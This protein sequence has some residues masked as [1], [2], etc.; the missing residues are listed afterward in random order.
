[1]FAGDLHKRS[2][3]IT[4]IEGYV[5]CCRKTQEDIMKACTQLGV[6]KFVSLGDWYD[7]GYNADVAASLSDYDIDIKM[8]NQLNGEF[9]GVIGNHIR[10]GMDSN[11]ELHIIQP[12]NVYKSRAEVTRTEQIMRTPKVL[13]VH[14]VQISFMHHMMGVDN[15]EAYK[16]MREPWAKYHIAL[17]HTPAVIPN[18][19]L[20]KA[21]YGYNTSSNTVIGRTLEGVDLAIVGDIHMPL[22]QFS[23]GTPTGTTTM[24]VPGSLTNTDSS[25]ETRHSTINIPIVVI[26]DESNVTLKYHM[27]DLNVNLCTF[28]RKNNEKATEKLKMLRGK[29]LPTLH[30]QAG[31]ESVTYTGATLNPYTTLSGFMKAQGY[32]DTDKKLVSAIMRTPEDLDAL[33]RIFYNDELPV[34]DA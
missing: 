23:I 24:I 11:P 4:T 34:T 26:D 9:Y 5:R 12:H 10:I 14:D 33:V 27:F 21:R 29:T 31:S 17:F 18:A 25:E 2:K 28:K 32:T 15:A 20:S 7:K 3:D 1:M 22:G 19:Q 6:T 30:E 8:A 16:P 13:R